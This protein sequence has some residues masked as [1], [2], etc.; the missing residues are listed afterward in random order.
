MRAS[1]PLNMAYSE[2]LPTRLIPPAERTCFSHQVFNRAAAAVMPAGALIL[3]AAGSS[4]G[5]GL[6]AARGLRA[7]MPAPL[8]AIGCAMLFAVVVASLEASGTYT[9]HLHRGAPAVGQA[10]GLPVT[11]TLPPLGD[12]RGGGAVIS[13]HPPWTLPLADGVPFADPNQRAKAQPDRPPV[14][15]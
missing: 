7:R 1:I 11:P 4:C 8:V 5:K 10:A 3:R 14:P 13:L 6:G 12:R 9:A 2:C 15:A